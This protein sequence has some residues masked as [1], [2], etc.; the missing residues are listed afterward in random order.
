MFKPVT[1]STVH[2]SLCNFSAFYPFVFLFV[3]SLRPSGEVSRGRAKLTAVT[4]RPSAAFTWRDLYT[5]T[6]C[7][8]IEEKQGS[9]FL[10]THPGFCYAGIHH[11]TSEV[12]TVS[13]GNHLITRNTPKNTR[14]DICISQSSLFCL[15]FCHTHSTTQNMLKCFSELWLLFHSVW[16]V[17]MTS[18]GQ[19]ACPNSSH[20][21]L[22]FTKLHR[23]NRTGSQDSLWGRGKKHMYTHFTNY[24]V[25]FLSLPHIRKCNFIY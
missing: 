22:Q 16:S 4:Y 8:H 3:P 19:S 21:K 1:F 2:N 24:V 23:L 9:R 25:T 10:P 6:Y 20:Y 11:T 18:V 15:R 13:D 14:T 7:S 5:K 17:Q 12:T